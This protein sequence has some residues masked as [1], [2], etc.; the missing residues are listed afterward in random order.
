[1]GRFSER[2]A[3][4]EPVCEGCRAEADGNLRALRLLQRRLRILS[5]SACAVALLGLGCATPAPTTGAPPR[6]APAGAADLTYRLLEGRFDSADQARSSPGHPAIQLVACAAD[7]PALGPR[8]L[9]VEQTRLAAPDTPIRQRVYALEA[10]EPI[11]SAAVSR[12][13]ELENPGAAVGAC[14]RGGPP[15]FAR[16]ELVERVGCAVALRAEGRVLRG[17]T[18][19]RGCP[20][21]H[22]GATYA[23]SELM[24]DDVGLRFWER[25]FDVTGAQRWGNDGVPY[26]FVRRTPLASR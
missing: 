8:V 7:V 3:D 9:Y 19:G 21:T 10:G 13:F 16:D 18:S 1:M 17:G 15:R 4:P 25:G 6:V 23:T 22:G 5:K 20:S 24:L 12:V 14:S 2:S 11:E 26:V